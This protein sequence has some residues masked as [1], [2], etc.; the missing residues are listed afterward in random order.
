MLS[1]RRAGVGIAAGVAVLTVVGCAVA[2]AGDDGRRLSPRASYDPF[3]GS[4]TAQEWVAHGDH[5]AVIRVTRETAAEPG[6]KDG[7]YVPRT[8]TATVTQVLW[9]RPRAPR[10]PEEI[11]LQAKG[12][13]TTLWGG[14]EEAARE[15]AP[16]L[17]PGHTYLVAVSGTANGVELIGDDA[18]LP[19]DAATFGQGEFEG[20]AISPNAYRAA[21]RGLPED[22]VAEFAISET[23]NPRTLRD[24]QRLLEGTSPL[25]LYRQQALNSLHTDVNLDREPDH[26]ADEGAGDLPGRVRRRVTTLDPGTDYFLSLACSGRGTAITL[27]LTVDGKTDTRQLPCNT[28]SELVAVKQPRDEV[29]YEIASAGPDIGAVAW[30]VSEAPG[31]ADRDG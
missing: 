24:V 17:E 8:V 18:A 10:L 3:Q 20:R 12:W 1:K 21:V 26:H 9:S 6:P 14:Q 16:R 15:G 2:I 30:N 27:E 22:A 4:A 5:A 29:A 13:Y 23:Y 31:H 28:G 11:T 19:Y 25:N 7:D